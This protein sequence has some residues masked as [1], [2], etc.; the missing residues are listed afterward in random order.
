MPILHSYPILLTSWSGGRVLG[1]EGA[2]SN[3]NDIYQINGYNNTND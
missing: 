3:T 1:G 2:A